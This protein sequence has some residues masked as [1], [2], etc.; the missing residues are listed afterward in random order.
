MGMLKH[1]FRTFTKPYYVAVAETVG[2]YLYK[3]IP[4]T[5]R[6]GPFPGALGRELQAVD[7]AMVVFAKS[8]DRLRMKLALEHWATR[9]ASPS[10]V[11]AVGQLFSDTDW[12][13]QCF[14]Y[15]RTAHP[16]AGKGFVVLQQSLKDVGVISIQTI[17]EEQ[18]NLLME[19]LPHL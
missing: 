8:N 16:H 5:T 17:M 9:I 14:L 3:L 19:M 4:A 13:Q 18:N 2:D 6:P 12:V 1:M 10:A 15:L 7:V 11:A